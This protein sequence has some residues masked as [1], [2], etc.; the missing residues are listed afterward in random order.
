MAYSDFITDSIRLQTVTL[1]DD[2]AGG[3]TATWTTISLLPC[4]IQQTSGRESYAFKR[5]GLQNVTRVWLRDSSRGPQGYASLW[6]F[7]NSSTRSECRFVYR[8]RRLRF[9]A[10]MKE[11]ESMVGS[12][13]GTIVVVDCEDDVEPTGYI[14]A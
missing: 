2:L 13:F 8:T 14:D 1:A 6:D 7:L 5:Y 9:L 11:Q 4:R 12:Q 10:F 3:Q